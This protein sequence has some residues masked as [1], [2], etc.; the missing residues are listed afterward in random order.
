MDELKFVRDLAE[1]YGV[2]RGD[3]ILRIQ[4]V[5]LINKELLQRRSCVNWA[6]FG[7]KKED[8]T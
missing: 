1:K 7:N 4:Y 3:V 2:E 6:G 8:N 5:R